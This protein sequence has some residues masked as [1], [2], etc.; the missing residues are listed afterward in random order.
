MTFDVGRGRSQCQAAKV[1]ATVI[2]VHHVLY[3]PSSYMHAIIA[4]EALVVDGQ[5]QITAMRTLSSFLM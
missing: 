3:G 5:Q 2:S 4:K 1:H